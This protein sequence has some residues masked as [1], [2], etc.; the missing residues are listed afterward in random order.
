MDELT[1]RATAFVLG[2]GGIAAVMIVVFLVI[3]W[4]IVR[5]V[6]RHSRNLT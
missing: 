6:G 2:L 4:L 1:D 5:R 3:G